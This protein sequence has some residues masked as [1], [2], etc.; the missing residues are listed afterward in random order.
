M[1]KVKRTSGGVDFDVDFIDEINVIKG[2]SGT[3]KTFL[4]NMLSSYCISNKIP[5]AFI[6][7]RFLAS[8]DEGLIFSLCINKKI[9]ILDNADLYLTPELFNKLRG[10][11]ATIILS[12]KHT[13]GLNMDDAHL[14]TVDYSG[15]S[16]STRWLC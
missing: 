4:F 5:F 7:Y 16:L 11:N 14:Y 12:K 2:A 15:S 6:G 13:F 8:G 9:I 3:G 1:L 10:L